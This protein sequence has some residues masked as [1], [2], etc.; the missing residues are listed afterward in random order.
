LAPIWDNTRRIFETAS[1]GAGAD[2]Q[3]VITIGEQ[4]GIRIFCDSEWAPE[5]LAR[6]HGSRESYVVT[7]RRGSV[8]VEGRACGQTCVLESEPPAAVARRLL[9]NQSRYLL[10]A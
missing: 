8:R 2:G 4:G 5:S 7:R 10:S 3:V 6:E 9:S 1:N